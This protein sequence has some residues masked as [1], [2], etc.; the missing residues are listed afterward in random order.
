LPGNVAQIFIAS[1][2]LVVSLTVHG[3]VLAGPLRSWLL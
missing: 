3:N 1:I 2:V